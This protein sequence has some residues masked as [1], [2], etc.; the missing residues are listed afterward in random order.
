MVSKNKKCHNWFTFIRPE[1]LRR[2]GKKCERCGLK[3]GE[4]HPQTGGKVILKVIHWNGNI[5]KNDGMDTGGECP[6]STQ[7][8][9]VLAVCQECYKDNELRLEM[10]RAAG[11][12]DD[13]MA[14]EFYQE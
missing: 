11:I 10:R 13:Q 4:R 8:A 1:V 12:R 6:K 2:S 9:N 14:F 3:V 5:S 7:Y